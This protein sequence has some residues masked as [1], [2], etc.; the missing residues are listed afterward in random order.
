[1]VRSPLAVALLAVSLAASARGDER[2]IVH[3]WGTF[4]SLEDESG[5]PIGGINTDDEPLP[6]FVH[7]LHRLINGPSEVPAVLFKG[8]PR[9]DPDVLVRL[10]TPVIYFHLPANGPK[11]MKLDVDVTFHGGWLTQYY[12]DAEVSA[13]GIERIGFDGRS[14]TL[15]AATSGTLA[16][17]GLVVGSDLPGPETNAQVWLAPR[18]V[19]AAGVTTGKKE[20]ERFLFYR[21]VGNIAPPLHVS[22][23]SGGSDLTIH[24]DSPDAMRTLWLV[25]VKA[26]GR[27]AMRSLG[28]PNGQQV[29][30]MLAPATL[31]DRE[32]SA[33]NVAL[34]RAALKTEMI[35]RGLFVDEA[36]ALLNTWEAS[37]FRRPGLRLFFMVP[38]TWTD[39]V[40]P[41]QLSIDAD[42]KRL[43]IGRIEI[44][45]PQ[46][47]ALLSAIAKGPASDP[48]TWLSAALKQAGGGREDYYREESFQRVMSGQTSLQSLH[49]T[50]PD[51]YRAY[52]QLGR[53]R[54]ALILDEARRRPTTELTTFIK[55]Y[56]LGSVSR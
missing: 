31:A 15:D 32:Y 44:V 38:A 1:M 55:N 17:R 37:Y 47:R 5:T 13:P 6:P 40:L 4:T 43:M 34:I 30:S 7:D 22:L 48:G 42:V 45:T 8:V 41:L 16:W 25:D 53:F 2:L 9:C 19:A 3:E 36:D 20:S 33:D 35:H 54:N 51:D 21:G 56:A 10:E 24:A 18:A 12:P 26:D 28:R 49:V 39:R 50:M 11:S 52:L 14:G 29:D 23:D 46:E 27:C